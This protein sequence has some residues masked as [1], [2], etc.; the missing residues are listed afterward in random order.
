MRYDA[1]WLR[2]QCYNCNINKSGNTVTFREKLVHDLGEEAVAEFEQ[3]R[4]T[5]V[6]DFNYE[7]KIQEY[8]EKCQALGLV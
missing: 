2:A 1:E 4:H 3:R 7:E 8:K 5:T 6:T